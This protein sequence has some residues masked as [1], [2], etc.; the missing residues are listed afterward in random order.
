MDCSRHSILMVNVFRVACGIATR[1]DETPDFK[2]QRVPVG[3]QRGVVD[4]KN[5][6]RK[7]SSPTSASSRAV[8]CARTPTGRTRARRCER[9]MKP[10]VG[11]DDV[12][13]AG[14][15]IAGKLHRTPVHNSRTLDAELGCASFFKCE[16][17][18]KVGAFKARGATNAVFA[19]DEA[20]ASQGVVTHSSGNHAAALAFAAALRGIRCT[21]V[22]PRGAPDVKVA[23][24]RGYGAEIVFCEP[25]ERE[26]T[27]ARLAAQTGAELVHP[28]EDP[29]VIAGQ[30]TAALELLE[31]VPELDLVIAP[32]GGG[33]LLSGTAITVAAMRPGARVLG[34]EP[35]AVDDAARSM[36]SGVRQPRVP[37]P[38]TICDGLLTAIGA[39]PFT[40]L[41][42]FGIEILTA[43]ESAIRDAARTFVERLK[44]VVEPSGAVP[45]AVLRTHRERF[46][47]K[48]V[49]VIVSGGNTDFRWL[50]E[51]GN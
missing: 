45:L 17:L 50:C 8:D 43:E 34:A 5:G 41:R 49:G 27:C 42:A 18:Q 33:G 12:L 10:D 25:A 9:E 24:V 35:A 29:R 21:V 13:A 48:R 51:P 47:G 26:A 22:M 38:R 15:R 1:V 46:A 39:R 14:A 30:G 40:I 2:L 4:H 19:L 37:D 7:A 20:S 32:V 28:F 11:F 44:L 23:A 6:K 16:N 36:H 31:Q 3:D